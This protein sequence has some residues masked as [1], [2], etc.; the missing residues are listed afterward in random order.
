LNQENKPNAFISHSSA[1]KDRFARSFA[2]NLHEDGIQAW[3]DE[4]EI[5]PGDSLIE[6]IHEEGIEK[7]DY[8][9]VILSKNS[10]DSEWV[11]DE[12]KTAKVK[13]IEG[14]CELISLRI[15]KVP[16]P[17]F[18]KDTKTPL[19]QNT[20]DY[21]QE[22]GFILAQ[23]FGYDIGPE[24]GEPPSKDE[25]QDMVLGGGNDEVENRIEQTQEYVKAS[26]DWR[27][28]IGEILRDLKAKTYSNMEIDEDPSWGRK[29][30]RCEYE[31]EISNEKYRIKT[32]VSSGWDADDIS[33]L[34]R[35]IYPYSSRVILITNQPI[36]SEL[37]KQLFTE[38]KKSES[39]LWIIDTKD[40]DKIKQ[41]LIDIL[42]Q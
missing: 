37:K 11:Q 7:C 13:H 6:K 42:A 26:F 24:I 30:T 12:L 39:D 25:V 40:E 4:W 29:K 21:Q 20:D 38:I 31:I 16:I 32:E 34:L 35:N 14:E 36:H 27:N 2:K 19:I 33:E 9:I 3:F 28:L 10:I 18:L 5:K 23:I 17:T 41:D 8:F 22:Y 15:D 1:D